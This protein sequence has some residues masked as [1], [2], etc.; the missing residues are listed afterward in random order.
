MSRVPPKS[1]EELSPELQAIMDAGDQ[2]MGFTS[3]DALVMACNAGLSAVGLP[4]RFD[5]T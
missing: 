4:A 3:N 1:R 5:T 2:I